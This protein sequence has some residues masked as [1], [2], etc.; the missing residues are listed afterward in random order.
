MD[1]TDRVFN[2]YRKCEKVAK[3]FYFSFLKEYLVLK[4]QENSKDFIY[5]IS[6]ETVNLR[7]FLEKNYR[8]LSNSTRVKL[9]Y[10]IALIL[11]ICKDALKG[12]SV[13]I[14]ID[15]LL[16]G[17]NLGLKLDRLCGN[18]A[19]M[20]E[21]TSKTIMRILFGDNIAIINRS[22]KKDSYT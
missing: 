1:N 7:R 20:D 21:D 11:M 16:V 15:N 2:E 9:S 19:K 17:I 4:G 10:D 5:Y 3:K 13:K 18:S 8:T 12:F 6:E 14:E 22:N